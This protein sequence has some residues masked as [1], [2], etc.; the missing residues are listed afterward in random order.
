VLQNFYI[1]N[2]G[3]ETGISRRRREYNINMHPGEVGYEDGR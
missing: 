3:R 1:D 2:F